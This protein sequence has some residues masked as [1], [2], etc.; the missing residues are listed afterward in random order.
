MVYNVLI[1]FASL[2]AGNCQYCV[3]HQLKCCLIRL[4]AGSLLARCCD[5]LYNLA[6]SK[7]SD[8]V[9]PAEN[10][11]EDEYGEDG[12]DDA[13]SPTSP[14]SAP[15]SECHVK[16]LSIG[17]IILPVFVIIACAKGL[18]LPQA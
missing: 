11:D 12:F 17:M 6:G 13:V 1:C 10:A 5:Y 14:D 7:L 2:I 16:S 18:A 15:T 8:E 9:F 4:A 3:L